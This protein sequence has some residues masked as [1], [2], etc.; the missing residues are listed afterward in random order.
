MVPWSSFTAAVVALLMG[1]SGSI[2]L[3][4]STSHKSAIPLP[5]L[6]L[7]GAKLGKSPQAGTSLSNTVAASYRHPSIST[8]DTRTKGTIGVSTENI[9]EFDESLRR[10]M[11]AIKARFKDFHSHATSSES[12]EGE[13]GVDTNGTLKS[14]DGDIQDYLAKQTK[15]HAGEDL[16]LDSFERRVDSNLKWVHQHSSPPVNDQSLVS[17]TMAAEGPRLLLNTST[18]RNEGDNHT[19]DTAGNGGNGG[20]SAPTRSALQW[21]GERPFGDEK[22]QTKSDDIT[23]FARNIEKNLNKAKNMKLQKMEEEDEEKFLR[24]ADKVSSLEGE[25]GKQKTAAATKATVFPRFRTASNMSVDVGGA[26]SWY[27]NPGPWWLPASAASSLKLDWVKKYKAF[28]K[29][30]EGVLT[31][32]DPFSRPV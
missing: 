20:W 12:G 1:T 32:Y 13:E 4:I 11:A 8:A 26:P 17:A 16:T 2:G 15:L 14:Y 24:E 19:T 31:V 30:P 29:P 18:I 9:D 3:T 27:Q 22:Q 5:A 21:E 23:T 6:S 10:R 7:T 25:D 28:T